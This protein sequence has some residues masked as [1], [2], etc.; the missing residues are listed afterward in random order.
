[1]AITAGEVEVVLRLRDEMS[2]AMTRVAGQL[3][4]AGTSLRKIGQQAAE[5]GQ[6]LLPLSVALSGAGVAALKFS[7]DFERAML[8]VSTIAAESAD[9]LGHMRQAVLDMAPRVG[10]GPNALAAAL[11]VVESTGIKG[12]Q[13][14]DILEKSAQASAA[15]LG[16]TKDIARAV[17]A[18]MV[19]YEKQGLSAAEATDILFQAVKEG[20]AEAEEFAGSLGRVIGLA[21]NIGVEFEEVAGYIA[22]F[23]RLGVDADEATT[24]LRGTM[25]EI[26]KVTPQAAKELAKV[27]TSFGG[28]S[29]SADELRQAVADK[30]LMP[31]LQELVATLNNDDEALA[32][33]FPNVRALAGILG[34]VG[35]QG[36]KMNE[37]MERI[38][39]SAG[40]LGSAF[41]RT[42]ETSAFKWSQ[43]KAAVESAAI[44]LGDKIAP[45]AMKALEAL[46]PILSLIETLAAAFGK[47]PEFM[48]T[49]ILAIAALFAVGGPLLIGLGM[50]IK[51]IGMLAQGFAV[52]QGAMFLFGNSI[53]V[54]TARLAI[55]E[56]MLGTKIPIA[57]ASF[58]AAVKTWMLPIA[59][60]AG[61][62]AAIIA[63]QPEVE[64]FF[65]KGNRPEPLDLPDGPTFIG[66][67]KP[68]LR[69]FSGRADMEAAMREREEALRQRQK[70]AQ[71][72][73]EKF[74]Q[75]GSTT[76]K[77]PPLGGGGLGEISEDI[78]SLMSQLS[79]ADARIEASNLSAAIKG[80]GGASKIAASELPE[81][82]DK[83]FELQSKG[84]KLDPVL[85]E[86]A[87]GMKSIDFDHP[88]RGVKELSDELS[89]LFSF[90]NRNEIVD[91]NAVLSE[92]QQAI[93]NLGASLFGFQNEKGFQLIDE[94]SRREI[95]A[96]ANGGFVD[97]NAV[98]AEWQTNLRLMV[99][100][101]FEIPKKAK[102]GKAM[103]DQFVEAVSA[104]P[105]MLTEAILHGQG[106]AEALRAT[107][108]G[109]FAG[110][111]QI[112]GESLAKSG[113]KMSKALGS[114]M[115]GIA[116]IGA[117]FLMG[118]K[119]GVMSNAAAGAAAGMM[120][121][122]WGAA[123]GAGIGAI[124]GVFKKGANDTRKAREEFAKSIGFADLGKLYDQLGDLGKAGEALRKIG[125]SVIGKHDAAANE[126]WMKD[127]KALLDGITKAFESLGLATARYGGTAP[128][129]L[130]PMVDELLKISGLTKDQ[131]ALLEGLS[132]EP[133]WQ[134][135][136]D[137]AEEYGIALDGLGEKFRQAKLDDLAVKYASDFEFLKE[138]G[139]DV[140]AVLA[141]M[142]DEVQ[143]LV[144]QALKFGTA[145]PENMRG[146]LEAMLAGGLLTD[147][148][149][150]ALLDLS[151]F[152]FKAKLEDPFDRIAKI[153]EDIYNLLA[154]KIP[155]ALR[156]TGAALGSIPVDESGNPRMPRLAESGDPN[157]DQHLHEFATGGIVRKAT[158]GLVGEA[159][160]EAI[161]PLDQY[162]GDRE[163]VLH[164]Y[165]IMDGRETARSVA[166]YLPSEV[167]FMK[168]A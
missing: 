88:K 33:I 42:A 145:I 128:K 117:D 87:Y 84:V 55:M 67:A 31:V 107:L 138:Q 40:A 130:K 56:T 82:V 34:T 48:Q 150:N 14:L 44:A 83:I 158:L 3:N 46:K 104:L 36:E 51:A 134:V 21:S 95:D 151:R 38:S 62:I 89:K 124:V 90:E 28:A 161:G 22:A 18:A 135:L 37:I 143:E 13:A 146:L 162:E 109:A 23:T 70:E 11:L 97:F 93:A 35:S 77:K 142:Q 59:I 65:N 126:K 41:G 154:G 123:V 72:L 4:Q 112:F 74:K 133:S 7:T 111:G 159:G 49:G 52:A 71:R 166:R 53:P 10:I 121:G 75:T 25:S 152:N 19:A 168:L 8:K 99:Q 103:K 131:R 9:S 119:G 147:E 101:L 98:E 157:F 156:A 68:P 114:V 105:G 81:L 155:D 94:R 113:S 57:M 76:G 129:S 144:T 136:Q 45:H 132:K 58:G 115:S 64:A 85:R 26:L 86:V 12:A 30:G 165:I 160:P 102:V 140:N 61:A 148:F 5:A 122:P 163:I 106:I 96:I 110:M 15:G 27:A 63:L 39:R 139:A 125:V 17:T 116:G 80:I 54:L 164:N 141:G 29:T 43:F 60:A 66:A 24:A 79:G 120:F 20:G 108:T 6:A 92:S 73:N 50:T 167:R 32:K 78:K 127:V 1:M 2:A 91:F 118:P 47:L 153:L 137:I 69:K 16:E 100:N 149:G